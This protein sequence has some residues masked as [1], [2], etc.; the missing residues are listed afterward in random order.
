[1]T[2]SESKSEQM[3][4]CQEE[5]VVFRVVDDQDSYNREEYLKR[6]E[7]MSVLL[8]EVWRKNHDLEIDGSHNVR[9]HDRSS[10]IVRKN[11]RGKSCF[12]M[13]IRVENHPF[14]YRCKKYVRC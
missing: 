8:E 5:R 12:V 4:S 11:W 2:P 10:K 13:H 3:H 9:R 1:M 7:T 6:R 14:H